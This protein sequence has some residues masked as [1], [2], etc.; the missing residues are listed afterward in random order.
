[1]SE[2]GEAKSKLLGVDVWVINLETK[3]EVI[4]ATWLLFD[5]KIENGT[6]TVKELKKVPKVSGILNN[7]ELSDDCKI[8]VTVTRKKCC[9]VLLED[10]ID[11]GILVCDVVFFD[12]NDAY[13]YIEEA[14]LYNR[15]VYPHPVEINT[16]QNSLFLQSLLQEV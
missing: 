13:K 2:V 7:E 3:D 11:F 4:G 15:C 9:F 14:K 16:F 6:Y 12:P 10:D 5:P 8:E 1:M